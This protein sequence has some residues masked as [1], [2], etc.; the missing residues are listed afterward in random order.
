[1]FCCSS[2]QNAELPLLINQLLVSQVELLYPQ[3]DLKY[4]GEVWVSSIETT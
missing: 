2:I 4:H 1:M 3:Y